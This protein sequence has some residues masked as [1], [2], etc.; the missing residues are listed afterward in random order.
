MTL[1]YKEVI[2]YQSP[3]DKGIIFRISDWIITKFILWLF[4]GKITFQ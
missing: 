4:T 2:V 1:R 3:K